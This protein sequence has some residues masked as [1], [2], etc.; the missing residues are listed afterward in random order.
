LIPPANEPKAIESIL[1]GCR[2]NVKHFGHSHPKK[3]CLVH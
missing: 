1:L 3:S 2:I